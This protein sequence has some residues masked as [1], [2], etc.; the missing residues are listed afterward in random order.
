MQRYAFVESAGAINSIFSDS[1]MF[2]MMIE[3]PS[4]HGRDLM[5]LALQELHLLREP[6]PDEELSRARNILKM[7]ILQSLERDEDRLE[8]M[9]K[10]Y[11]TYGSLTFTNYLENIDNVSSKS[12]NSLAIKMLKTPPTLVVAGPEIDT[13]QDAA[14][15]NRLLNG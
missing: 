10:N 3:G 4:Q 5:F 14:E 2:G 6:I 9:T 7:N 15:V 12:I 13:V 1:G 8:E 11:A